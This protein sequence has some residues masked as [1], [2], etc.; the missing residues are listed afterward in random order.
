MQRGFL[1]AQA[2]RFI[3]SAVTV[4]LVYAP[5]CHFCEDARAAL[6]EIARDHELTVELI[7]ADSGAGQDLVGRHRPAMFPLVLVDGA[8]FSAGRLPRGKL[9]ALLAARTAAG[10]RS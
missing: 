8:F 6:D 4:T 7:E 5:A 9:R 3:M 1:R 2:F 10:V